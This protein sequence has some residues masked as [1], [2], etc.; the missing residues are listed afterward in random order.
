MADDIRDRQ[1]I[2][3][4][5]EGWSI[6]RDSGDWENFRTCWH[7]GAI[8]NATWFQGPS[9]Q[10]I[11][12]AAKGFARGARSSHHLGG[13][14]ITVKGRRAVAQ[15]RMTIST[16]ERV[17]GVTC[18]IVSTGRFLDFFEKRDGRWAI[19]ERH[20]IYDKDRLDPLDPSLPPK[21]DPE[22]LNSLPE[23]YRHLA[24]AQ[25]KRGLPVKRDMPGSDGPELAAL[26]ERATAWLAN[27]EAPR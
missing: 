7:D 10:F 9:D 20:P 8:M 15:T 5:I 27:A 25:V 26:Y 23:G 19:V 17:E 6:W 12:K 3:D 24:Y 14:A 18:D 4:C 16:R 11:E 22:L 2:R 13:T 1:A 21:L